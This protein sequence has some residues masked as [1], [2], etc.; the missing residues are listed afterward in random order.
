M[1]WTNKGHEL[2]AFAEKCLSVKRIYIW[3]IGKR[4]DDNRAKKCIDYLR[5]LKIDKDFK[6]CFVDAEKA[7]EQFEGL[8]VLSPEELFERFDDESIVVSTR[9][10]VSKCSEERGLR[11]FEMAFKFNGK[12]NFVQHFLSVYMLYKHD[13][14]ISYSMNYNITTLCNLNCKGCLNFNHWIKDIKHET[15]AEFKAHMDIVFQKYESAYTFEITGGEPLLNKELPAILKWFADNYGDRVYERHVVTNG[16]VIP[17]DELLEVLRDGGYTIMMDDYRDTVALAEKQIPHIEEKFCQWGIPYSFNKAEQWWDLAV[18]KAD[19]TNCSEEE[20]IRHRDGC[21]TYLSQMI[22]GRVYSCCYENYARVAGVVDYAD[23]LDLLSTPNKELL[24]YRL[25][26]TEKGYLDM[27]KHCY[28]LGIDS[29]CQPPAV[30]M[31]KNHA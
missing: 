26:Y 1:K 15:L 5:W 4:I 23:S 6:I 10:T 19:F 22:G 17:S 7:G 14:F 28:G 18:G 2:D 27:C 16:T 30:Q 11:Y 21:N 20:L 13:R 9:D 29:I 24:E 12:Q 8:P 31:P 25:G 3:E